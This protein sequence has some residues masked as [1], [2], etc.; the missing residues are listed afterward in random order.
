MQEQSF[1]HRRRNFELQIFHWEFALF[2]GPFFGLKKRIQNRHTINCIHKK[3]PCTKTRA[4]SIKIRF[5]PKFYNLQSSK[6]QQNI[7]EFDF[8]C[9][10]KLSLQE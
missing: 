1:P 10:K 9:Y 7:H 3:S 5:L 4:F 6:E 8:R 2:R